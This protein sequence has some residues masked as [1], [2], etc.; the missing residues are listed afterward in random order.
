VF[1]VVALMLLVG[2]VGAGRMAIRFPAD[3]D[4][5]E[6]TGPASFFC[7]REGALEGKPTNTLV[8][9]DYVRYQKEMRALETQLTKNLH[10]KSDL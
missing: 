7:L 5:T 8:C 10:P 3:E 2:C 6:T 4:A 9:V 1:R